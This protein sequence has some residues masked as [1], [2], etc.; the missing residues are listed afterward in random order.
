MRAVIQISG[1]QAIVG[2]GDVLRVDRINSDKKT[3][4]YTPLLVIDDDKTTVGTPEVS[5]AKVTAE[6]LEAEAKGD[7]V[8]IMKFQAKKR[9][10]KMTGHRQPQSVIRIKSIS[11]K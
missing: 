7:K 5:G 8:K 6:V 9:V 3:V 4:S 10:K 11:N 2:K 1:Q